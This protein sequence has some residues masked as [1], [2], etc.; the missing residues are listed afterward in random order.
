MITNALSD[1]A[2]LSMATASSNGIGYTSRTTVEGFFQS[3]KG[4]K[5]ERFTTLA[6]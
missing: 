2:L 6:D 1:K 4:A 3:W 5:S